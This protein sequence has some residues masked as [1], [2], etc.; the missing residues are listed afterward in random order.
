MKKGLLN[1]TG[2]QI[3]KV[4][5][6][7]LSP[8]FLV[9]L[10]GS[11]LMWYASMLNND[12]TTEMPLGIRIDGQKYRL[13]ATVSGRGSAI[14]AQRLALKRKLRFSLD[15][16]SSRP[17]RETAGALTITNTSLQRAINS[18]I[19][20]ITIIEVIEAPEF[21]PPEADVSENTND[22]SA[23][24]SREK[25]KRER[26]EARQAKKAAKEAAHAAESGEEQSE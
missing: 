21:T 24:T 7:A 2:D 5:R 17:S 22:P 23:E 16:L 18:K 6:E 19:T 4:I 13:T 8:T 25:R 9:I 14:L 10:A 11:A 26:R 3:R 1:I 12:Y 15:E 20:E